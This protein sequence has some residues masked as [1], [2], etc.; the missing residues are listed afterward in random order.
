MG[1]LN[2]ND[3]WE[4][5]SPE[6]DQNSRRKTIIV[7]N[8]ESSSPGRY[9]GRRKSQH[10]ASEYLYNDKDDD[11]HRESNE[12][13]YEE[14]HKLRSKCTSDDKDQFS[15]DSNSQNQHSSDIYDE[16]RFW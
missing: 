10:L 11:D 5:A 16:R 12:D 9:N 7:Q 3:R 6:E 13:A 8:Y 4:P 15:G 2:K 14:H 1:N